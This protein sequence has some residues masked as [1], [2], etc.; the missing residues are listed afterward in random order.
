M[1]SMFL[2]WTA[3][4]SAAVASSDRRGMC[5]SHRSSREPRPP[6]LS[7]P[8]TSRLQNPLRKFGSTVRIDA[9]QGVQ[10]RR[11]AFSWSAS[12]RHGYSAEVSRRYARRARKEDTFAVDH[13]ARSRTRAGK[14]VAR[15]GA[16]EQ[17]TTQRTHPV[18]MPTH[19]RAEIRNDASPPIGPGSVSTVTA[20]GIAEGGPTSLFYPFP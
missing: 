11:G 8:R 2:A 1:T 14:I 17:L 13:S 12:W 6:Y 3:G 18:R 20:N 5:R 19:G 9:A 10:G 7:Q 16:L 15:A 4:R